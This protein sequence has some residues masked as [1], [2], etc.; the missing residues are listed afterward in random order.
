M[1]VRL[2]RS[3]K[4]DLNYA[5][6][7]SKGK[8]A[9]RR[10]VAAHAEVLEEGQIMDSPLHVH[11]SDD[12]FTEGRSMGTV[13]ALDARF[14]DEEADSQEGTDLDYLDD[15][16]TQTLPELHKDVGDTVTGARA[17]EAFDHDF[18]LDNDKTWWR[19]EQNMVENKEKFQCLKKKLQRQRQLEEAKLWEEQE[20]PELL[21]M[22]REI[23]QI[24]QKRSVTR[25]NFVRDHD[26]GVGDKTNSS[27]NKSKSKKVAFTKSTLHEAI[28]KTKLS[29]KTR[30]MDWLNSSEDSVGLG[31]PRLDITMQTKA[32]TFS[33]VPCYRK[34]VRQQ[35]KAGEAELVPEKR[36]PLK[37]RHGDRVVVDENKPA[38]KPRSR[39]D[40]DS[41]GES[42]ISVLSAKSDHSCITKQSTI[43]IKSSGS[44]RAVSVKI[45]NRNPKS[46]FLDKPCTRVLVKHTWPHMS[47]N[48]HYVPEP[49]SFNQLSFQ[50]FVG[51][52][53]R[54]ILKADSDEEIYGRLRILSKVAYL[55]EQCKNWDKARS[56]Y[57]AIISSIEE[58]EADWSSTF[59]HYDL[60]CPA[61]QTEIRMDLVKVDA[62]AQGSCVK[63]TTRKDY[64]CKDFQ[65]GNCSLTP[66]HKAWIRNAWEM[67]DHFCQ[68][69][70]KAKRVN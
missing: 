30:V 45:K 49:L 50:Q 16:D 59:G 14:A 9:S 44:S 23:I 31:S 21:R 26:Q 22:E 66:P 13:S 6:L 70:Y 34:E 57:F 38:P 54:T 40:T 63:P 17:D 64:F 4:K 18:D 15:V 69:C 60:M 5:K 2:T 43:T 33:C 10:S 46:G 24:K 27:R 7:N 39:L 47:Q 28:P 56:T 58:G 62:C 35:W 48:P 19:Q 1:V 51:G 3:A 53:T 20:K 61:P 32:D 42:V 68:N 29:D 52:E 11:V 67:V 55:F 25:S 8:E 41:D 65:K 36:A 37:E 12:E